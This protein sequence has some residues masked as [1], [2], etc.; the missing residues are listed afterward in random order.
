MDTATHLADTTEYRVALIDS[1]TTK[2]LA[3]SDVNGLHLPRVRIPKWTRPAEEI[4]DAIRKQWQVT[5]IVLTLLE[6]TNDRPGCAV[7]ELLSSPETGPTNALLLKDIECLDEAELNTK[8]RASLTSLIAGDAAPS[9]PFS[10][11]G[12]LKEAQE[13]IQSSIP[14]ATSSSPKRSAS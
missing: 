4:N 2:L 3:E 11:R 6:T 14:N 1:F 7:A 10:H 9:G 13:W 12:W 8:E 5:S